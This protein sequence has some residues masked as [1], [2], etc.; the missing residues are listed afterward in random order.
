MIRAAAV[1]QLCMALQKNNENASLFL[2]LV[3][4]K[5]LAFQGKR[6]YADSQL[7]RLKHRLMQV[8]LILQPYLSKVFI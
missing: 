5:L 2:P 8:L 4:E 6:Y 3:L 1:S 7:H